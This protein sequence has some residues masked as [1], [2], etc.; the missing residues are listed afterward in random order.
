MSDDAEPYESEASWRSLVEQAPD[1]I[2]I[3]DREG[4]I[5]F[6][7]HAPA[8]L[9]PAQAVGT[10]AVDYVRPDH[11][12]K[13]RQA[14]EKVF[15]TGETASF[16]I[17]ARGP[18]DTVAWYT[19]RLGPVKRD[20]E[21]IAVLL[22]TR[23][24][25][26]RK[27]IEEALR[28]SQEKYRVLVEQSLQG[29]IIFQDDRLVF[30]NAA[31][32]KI[33]GYT[34]D[35]LLRLS[36]NEIAA[37]VDEERRSLVFG[38]ARQRLAGLAEPSHY[39]LP[40]TTKDGAR[41]WVEVYASRIDY[42][43][44]PA[45]QAVALDI[46]DRRKA[47]EALRMKDLAI[48]SA[49]SG[50]A[51][52]DLDGRVKFANSACYRMWGYDE[53]DDV[54]GRP[55]EAFWHD[56]E[57]AREVIEQ[58]KRDGKW[59]GELFAKRK[60]G[61]P[62]PVQ[63]SAS[64]VRDAGGTPVGLM[65]SLVDITDRKQAEEALRRSEQRYRSFIQNL[66]GIAFRADVLSP[67][68]FVPLFL[69]GTV[70]AITGRTES[71]FIEG[72]VRWDDVIHPDDLPLLLRRRE[73]MVA[74][75]DY[76]QEV[77]YRIIRKDGAVRWVHEHL[78]SLCD[79]SG[80]VTCVQGILHDVT[81]R[82]TAE[83]ERRNLERQFQHAQKLESL[84]VL[85]GGIAHDFNNLLTGILGNAELALMELPAA[86]PARQSIEEVKHV[87]VRA[88]DLT[89]QMLA[90]SGRGLF[91]VE[92]LDLSR[93][94]EDMARLLQVSVQKNVVLKLALA[95]GLPPVDVDAAQ[96]RQIVMNLVTNASDSI[97]E[98]TGAVTVSTG[99]THADPDDL[100][101][102]HLAEDMPEGYYVYLEVADT[103]CGMDEQTRSKLFDPFFTT[104]FTGRGLGLAAALG[105]VRGHR[106]AIRVDSSPGQ[107]S[108]FRVLLPCS[109]KSLDTVAQTPEP[110][111]TDDSPPPGGTILIVEDEE[112]VRTT[113]RLILE[114][115]GYTVL[116]ATN[117][118]EGAELFR[119]RADEVSAVL[120]DMTMPHMGG[121]QTFRQLRHVRPDVPVVLCSGYAEEDAVRRFGQE[122]LAGFL[123]K[124]FSLDDLLDKVRQALACR[125]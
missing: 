57:R 49:I 80:K 124:P 46:T 74:V 14:V 73:A 85:A 24:I 78:Q 89:N 36:L 50:I 60:N 72:A 87:A 108:T 62:F 112:T 96:I 102:T 59:A 75:P 125:A 39:E 68:E 31:V 37:I 70:E 29:M 115:R 4:K 44:R 51:M 105:I 52:A 103:G 95:D 11:R 9:T 8:P 5:L 7:N 67:T 114:R 83:A 84:G 90:Y 81:D 42:R 21:I 1:I 45:V 123:K 104:K 111:A 6:I 65:S 86:S 19:T 77:E 69:H 110:A 66:E 117:G 120:L 10:N 56:A 99:L 122:G 33:I 54:L 79:A 118:R 16:E 2:F 71:Q 32:A 25:S 27:R 76:R 40:V 107:G 100:R 92:T 23:D 97:G 53:A 41:R 88:S 82:K 109:D 63:L 116:T 91:V 93:L 30:V 17:A 35:E 13:V 106:G 15:E 22:V 34:V 121:P 113:T 98:R 101:Q 47:A 3:V 12:E 28:E 55:T 26:D 58:V 64:V 61:D 38:R 119:Q 18:H 20:G 43:G 94:V 48:A